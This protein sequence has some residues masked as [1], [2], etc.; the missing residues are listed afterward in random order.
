MFNAFLFLEL[1]KFASMGCVFSVLSRYK[2]GNVS[3]VYIE[4]LCYGFV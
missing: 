3:N 2:V 1:K 4:N